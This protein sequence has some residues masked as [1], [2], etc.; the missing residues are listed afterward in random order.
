VRTR[1]Y[2][3]GEI[4][5]SRVL[6]FSDGVFAI[7]VTLLVVGI[8]VPTVR[9]SQLGDALRDLRPEIISFFI[10]FIVIGNYWLA[11]HRFVAQL[12][13]ITTTLMT[14]N[15]V[16]LAAIAFVPFPTALVGKYDDSPV[17]VIIYAITLSAASSLEVVMFVTARHSG[18]TRV[19][20]PD[21]VFRYAVATS[22]VPVIV[23]V[24][25]IPVAF[26]SASWAL[27]SWLLIFPAEHLLDRWRPAAAD[28]L[29]S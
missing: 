15:L 25:S 22:S 23:F 26:V 20:I 11:H 17:T 13:R 18:S 29:L 14:Q 16:Y 8:G 12:A 28:E 5:F 7:A 10:S 27:L 1:A 24:L 6:A 4:E 21:D 9:E 2:D 3:R 19:P